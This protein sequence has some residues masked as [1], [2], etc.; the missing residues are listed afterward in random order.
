MKINEEAGWTCTFR[1]LKDRIYKP[2]STMGT[3]TQ[4]SKYLPGESEKHQRFA[5]ITEAGCCTPK[6]AKNREI[7]GDQ[8]NANSG[9][10]DKKRKKKN[11]DRLDKPSPRIS[12]MIPMHGKG[13]AFV[14]LNRPGLG[15]RMC[16]LRRSQEM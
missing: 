7:T 15:Q 14:S 12:D 6:Q 10:K 3:S 1:Y 11:G 8:Y 2:L 4:Y 13:A 5:H 16:H 9:L